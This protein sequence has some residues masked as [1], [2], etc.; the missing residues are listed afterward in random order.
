MSENLARSRARC[1]ERI[2]RIAGAFVALVLVA[3]CS[4]AAPALDASEAPPT[5]DP[6]AR[7]I[8][9]P[10]YP[11]QSTWNALATGYSNSGATSI[12]EA[13]TIAEIVVVGRFVGLERGKAYGAPGEDVGWYATASIEIDEVLSGDSAVKQGDHVAVPLM[14]TM[15]APGS[16]FPEDAFS[17]MERSRPVQPAVLFLVSWSTVW[18]R[19]NTKV[20]GWLEDLDRHDLYRTIGIDG[21]LPLEDGR[22][23]EGVDAADMA[24]WRVE[25]AGTRLRS[26]A[27]AIAAAATSSQP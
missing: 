20:P 4:A 27:E 2:L 19:V 18:D 7:A 24:P 14:L 3:A 12:D 23:S 6:S 1:A 26:V 10:T 9:D 11:P 16:E 22:I 13:V 15:A 25:V 8:V 21:A 17:A 5:Q